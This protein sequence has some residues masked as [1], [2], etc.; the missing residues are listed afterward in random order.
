[1]ANKPNTQPPKGSR[2][3]L[4]REVR[5]R[6]HVLEKVR[7]VY[8]RYGFEPLETP[9]MERL[10][11]LLGKYGEEGDQL[12]FR[13]LERGAELGRA[14]DKVRAGEPGD[15]PRAAFK[16]AERALADTAL[17]YDLTVPLARVVAQYQNELPR[18]F[19]RYQCQPVWRADRPAKGRFREFYQCDVDIIGS[20]SLLC[21]LE[22][23]SAVCEVLNGLGF[24]DY[25]IRL[26][27]RGL[28]RGLVEAAG[29]PLDKEVDAI[30]A[31]DKLDKVG[32]D[33][34]REELAQRGIPG[35]QAGRFVE[36]L[37][38]AQSDPRAAVSSEA[39]LRAVDALAQ[40]QTW[41]SDTPCGARLSLDLSLAR[42][43]GYY[44][45]PIFEVQVADLAGSLGGGGR[46]DGL[47]GMFL[48]NRQL[49]AVGFSLGLERILV[50][51][52]E[53]GMFPAL[54]SSAQV[55]VLQLDEATAPQTLKLLHAIRAGGISAELYPQVDKLGKQ[56]QY[57]EGRG[58]QV[59]AFVGAAERDA[60]VCALKVMKTQ[61]QVSAP[62][63]DPLGV[64]RGLLA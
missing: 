51:M 7:A 1:M 19:K 61:Q 59:V 6:E 47:V 30:T 62:L 26:N 42:G 36:N 56:F 11:T 46:Y 18:F 2:D 5:K 21:E 50:V 27:H 10:D 4:P 63:T 34:V 20:E 12:I 38:R 3:F 13:V 60:G 8:H 25:R 29:I 23:C 28:L 37:D 44:T 54:A 9:A 31:L 49:P 43:L 45:G 53:R 24:D 22:V 55:M 58:A 17:R 40:L 48:G 52:E 15:D 39:A 33:G 57:A 35:E 14:L 41:A 64:L 16:Q 32:V